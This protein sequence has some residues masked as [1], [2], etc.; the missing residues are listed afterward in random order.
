M[1]TLSYGNAHTIEIDDNTLAHL[2]SVTFAKLRGQEA[3][4]LT[5]VHTSEDENGEAK[6]AGS[7]SLWVSPDTPIVFQFSDTEPDELSREWIEEL[8]RSSYENRGLV[9]SVQ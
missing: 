1:G 5:I 8:M 7:T 2:R 6:H 4:P 3:F 9:I